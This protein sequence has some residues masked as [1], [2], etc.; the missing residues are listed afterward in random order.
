MSVTKRDNLLWHTAM[1]Q[2]SIHKLLDDIT[3]DEAFVTIGSS[4][5]HICWLT[6][7]LVFTATLRLQCL[8]AQTDTPAK[9]MALFGRGA[10][11]PRERTAFPP[12]GKIREQL[13]KLYDLADSASADCADDYLDQ[14]IET[15]PN[16][17]ERVAN[18][19]AFFLTHDFYHAGH[20]AMIRRE[21]GRPPT[22][23]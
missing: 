9:W 5:N 19:L 11:N 18:Y 12:F 16:W 20:I 6:G 21:L 23:G 3:V 7:H 15:I 10:S 4:P 17:K 1:V 14:T 13:F 8:Q 22:F 2:K